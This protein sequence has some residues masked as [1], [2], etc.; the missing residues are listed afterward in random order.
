MLLS[1]RMLSDVGGVN[2]FDVTDA[3]RFSVGDAPAVYF[4]LIDESLDRTSQGYNPPGRRY[5][6]AALAELEVVLDNI[7]TA[8]VVT[9]DATQ[10]FPLDPS[11]WMI[12]LM[13]TD[14]VA[15][16]VNLRLKLTEGA[17][18]TRGGVKRALLVGEAKDW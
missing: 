12:Q 17:V 7:D 8:K 1:A 5:M 3:V 6:P 18:V 9:R 2:N 10:P 4:Q 14:Q 13:S 16:T 15:G 11:I